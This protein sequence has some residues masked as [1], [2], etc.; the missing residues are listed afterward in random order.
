[1]FE[2]MGVIVDSSRRFG[3][4]TLLLVF[5]A[6]VAVALGGAA[7]PARWAAASPVCCPAARMKVF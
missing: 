4:I 7:L 3:P 1:M 6:T 5:A 2:F